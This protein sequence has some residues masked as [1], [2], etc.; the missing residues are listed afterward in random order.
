MENN[1]GGKVGNNDR[2]AHIL[3]EE[4]I[5]TQ[6]YYKDLSS[7]QK[8][9]LIAFVYELSLVLYNSYFERDE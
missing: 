8:S 6:E 3:T 2:N 1:R 9:E 4:D 7:Q 5:N